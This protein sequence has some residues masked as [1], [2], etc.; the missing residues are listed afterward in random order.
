MSNYEERA[1]EVLH[2]LIDS[3]SSFIMSGQTPD[4]AAL[5]GMREALAGVREILVLEG[6]D[7]DGP[8]GV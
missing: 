6:H 3:L 1:V 7:R 4:E 8:T 5:R 2:V